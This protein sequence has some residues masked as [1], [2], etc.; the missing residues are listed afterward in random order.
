MRVKQ[1]LLL[2]FFINNLAFTQGESVSKFDSL[3]LANNK[4]KKED[5][6]KGHLLNRIAFGYYTRDQA[7]GTK[8]ATKAIL[9]ATKI[10]NQTLLADAYFSYGA[11]VMANGKLEDAMYYYNKALAIYSKLNNNDGI[12]FCYDYIAEVYRR[13]SKTRELLLFGKKSLSYFE[14]SGNQTGQADIYNLYGCLN[15]NE[16][17]YPK[18]IENFKKAIDRNEKIKDYENLAL[19]LNNLGLVYVNVSNFSPALVCFQKAAEYN[20]KLG[21]KMW[22]AMHYDNIAWVNYKTKNYTQSIKYY[23][24]SININQSL[25]NQTGY[26]ANCNHIGLVYKDAG[27][28]QKALNYFQIAKVGSERRGE[29]NYLAISLYNIA[30][31]YLNAPDIFLQ[32]NQI[33]P[34]TKYEQAIKALNKSISISTEINSKGILNM[35]LKEKAYALE[36]QKNYQAAIEY[37]KKYYMMKDSIEGDEVKSQ[38]NRKQ[39]QFEFEKKE[40]ILNGTHQVEL[41]KLKN[42][43]LLLFCSIFGILLLTLLYFLW[44]RQKTLKQDKSNSMNFTKQL[45][46]N[47]EDERKRIASDLHDSISHELLN[48]KSIFKQ[49]FSLVNTKIDSIINDIRGISRNLH[50]VM[51]DKIG[52]EPNIEQLV[53]R[54]QHQNDFMVSTEIDYKGSLSSADELQI[55]RII[56][57]ALTNIIKYAKAHAGKI[58]MM[59]NEGN[60]LVEIKDN[61]KGFNVKEAL[62]SGKAFGLHNIIERSRV[63]GGEAKI[64]SSPE[65]TIINITIPQKA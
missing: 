54:I 19:N 58:T 12:G 13:K 63:I 24:K 20:E 17:N 11:N 22:L 39:A 62:N 60:V 18:A 56:Q 50:P 65:G 15:I 35:S 55:Y 16:A 45:L 1:S 28:F 14:Q 33:K 53:E 51:F 61:G 48:L 59:E 6:I 29:K 2:V 64:Q 49:D 43:R 46:E 7:K 26:T 34:S 5:A 40:V 21:N 37:Y 8:I 36:K 4:Y 10:N 47:T 52:L 41:E 3:L 57:E 32:N 23:Q 38:I 30:T 42:Q 31:I 44:I 27:D 25:G 9:L